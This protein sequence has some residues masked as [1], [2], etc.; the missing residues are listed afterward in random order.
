MFIQNG[1]NLGYS[2]GN[3]VGLRYALSK[4]DLEYVWL[5]NNDTLPERRALSALVSCA[6]RTEAAMAGSKLLYAHQPDTLQMAGGGMIWPAAGNSFI[7]ASGQKDDGRWD[8]PFTLDYVC[9]ASLLA[10]REVLLRAGLLDERYF[11]YWEDA[12]W[13]AR[14]RRSGF[15]LVYCPASRVLHKEGATTGKE[16]E[17][18]AG[19]GISAKADYYWVRN[20]LYF[21]KKFHPF[22]LF[23][24]P[25]AYLAKYTVVR[26]ARRQPL[27]LKY[28]ILGFLDFL[29]GR[30]GHKTF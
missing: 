22:F 18:G 6:R 3:N 14:A 4:S 15:K 11:L 19:S 17:N 16:N 28:F 12:D 9:G 1:E 10:S 27:N 24:V 21:T 13:G 20:G 29:Y 26:M 7:A 25:L 5:L 30:T 23:S 2:G 8:E